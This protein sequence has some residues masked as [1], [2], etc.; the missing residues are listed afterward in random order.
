MV[1]INV[2]GLIYRVVGCKITSEEVNQVLVRFLI[3]LRTV[4]I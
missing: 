4:V 2:A 1:W 3:F